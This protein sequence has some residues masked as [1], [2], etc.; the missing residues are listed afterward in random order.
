MKKVLIIEDEEII[1]ETVSYYFTH[2]G[3]EVFAAGDG[4]KGMDLFATHS[5]EL[6]ILDIMVPE[7]DG[8]T[9]CRRIRRVSTV[10]IIL[11]TARNDEED[12]LLGFELGADDY[13]TKPFK[14]SILLAR[15]N[16]LLKYHSVQQTQ[17]LDSIHLCGINIDKLA[18][19]VCIDG[20][21]INLTLTEYEILVCLMEHKEQVI[22][23]ET[24]ITHIWGYDYDGDNK[25]LTTHMRNM[26]MKLGEKSKHITTVI[27]VGYKFEV[28]K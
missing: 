9:V 19:T 23:R 15:A 28:E 22:T 25:T 5:I 26:R 6:V 4:Q 8:W 7:I 10:P 1:R 12:T 11:L 24:L 17:Q 27:R 20:K 16:R 18:R 2:E 3:Y 13:V 21:K 14:P